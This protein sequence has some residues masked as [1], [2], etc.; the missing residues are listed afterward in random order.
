VKIKSLCALSIGIVI[1]LAGCSGSDT[2]SGADKAKEEKIARLKASLCVI[3]NATGKDTVNG[4]D[5]IDVWNNGEEP[6]PND[7]ADAD[8]WAKML[9]WSRD[10]DAL[11]I[12]DPNVLDSVDGTGWIKFCNS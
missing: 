1:L 7:P 11:L 12:L 8:F 10:L 2:L 6:V 3:P 4:Q 5:Q 9:Q